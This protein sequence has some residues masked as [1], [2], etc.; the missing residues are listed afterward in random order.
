LASRRASRRSA[1][2]ERARARYRALAAFD[3]GYAERGLPLIVGVDEAGRGAL[4]GPVV[5]A[6]V[7]LPPACG[8]LEVDDSKRLS[9]R[10][11]ERL[12]DEI[13]ARASGVRI[14]F[15]AP[16]VIDRENILRATLMSMHRAVEAL[17]LRP[18]LVLVDGRDVFQWRGTVVAVEKGDG[19]SLSIAAASVV[20]K[21][22]RDRA[23]RRLDR[24]FPGY[25]LGVNKGY[26]TRDHLEAIARLGPT[27]A[28]RRTFLAKV[29]ENNLSMF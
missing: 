1:A 17:G 15:G 12:F 5:A 4:A 18:D 20:A 9:E 10:A 22:A 24:R 2:P 7:V 11:R 3:R 14:A 29:V 16:A 25:N 28:H 26:G 27:G 13:V 19:R 6:A 8:L 23:M 21:V